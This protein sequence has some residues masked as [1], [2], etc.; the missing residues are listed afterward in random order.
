MIIVFRIGDEEQLSKIR[1]NTLILGISTFM[2]GLMVIIYCLHHWF[3]F[4]GDYALLQGIGMLVG[5]KMILFYTLLTLPLLLLGASFLLFKKNSESEK[6][7]LLLTLTLTFT[8]IGMISSGNG[9]VEYHF[10]IFMMLAIITYFQS[11]QLIAVSTIVFAVQHFAGYF[12]FPEL[13]CGTSD[14]RFS[15]LMIHAVYLILTA[16]ANGLII[17]NSKR[18]AAEAEEKRQQSLKLYEG[19]VNQL[20][21]TSASIL[22]VSTQVDNGAQGTEEASVR[23]SMVS[24]DLCDGADNLKQSVAENVQ[25]VENLLSSAEELNDGAQT[26]NASASRTAENV[27]QGTQLISTAEEQFV[28]VERSVQNLESLV[29]GFHKKVN[30]INQ[31]VTQIS[32]IADQTNLL[33]LNASIEAARAGDAGKGFAVVAGEVRNLAAESE[34]SAHSIREL[35]NTIEKEFVVISREMELCVEEVGNGTETMR[36]SKEIFEIITHSMEDVVKE[37]K[38]IVHVSQSLSTDGSKMGTSMGKMTS[39]SDESSTNSREIAAAAQAQFASVEALSNEAS[40]L[41][42]QSFEL[43]NIVRKISEW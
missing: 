36:S 37:M 13:L 1:G 7:P 16:L 6:I 39:V 27:Q 43:E 29:A 9:F 41:R 17:L 40:T 15:L 19:I 42:S 33:A 35:V 28:T 26:V 18:I 31:F 11:I 2:V 25:Y 24:T 38:T 21:Q 3:G 12:F 20:Q 4:L 8:S 5:G 14:Y 34:Q 10:S 23:I 32:L 30:E 22:A